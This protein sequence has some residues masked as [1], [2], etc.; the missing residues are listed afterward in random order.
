MEVDAE[1]Y[2]RLWDYLSHINDNL[3]DN[4]TYYKNNNDSNNASLQSPLNPYNQRNKES[5]AFKGI[6]LNTVNKGNYNIQIPDNPFC[7][8]IPDYNKQGLAKSLSFVNTKSKPYKN[9]N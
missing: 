7:P 2:A 8:S 4:N 6:T 5:S 9:P 1:N 3:Q